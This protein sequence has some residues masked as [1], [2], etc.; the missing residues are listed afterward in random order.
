MIMN[1]YNNPNPITAQD[2]T[3]IY[4]W[5]QNNQQEPS[6]FKVPSMVRDAIHHFNP[7]PSPAHFIAPIFTDGK[8]AM[9]NIL[10]WM[11]RTNYPA[12]I[13]IN[14]DHWV[15]I[16]GF[17]TDQDPEGHSTINLQSIDINDSLPF[18]G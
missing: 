8:A 7:P 1:S 11:R 17:E 12:A 14:G 9:Y 18:C 3:N 2:Q 6:P 15:V 10:L 16:T 4:N 13:M 5:I